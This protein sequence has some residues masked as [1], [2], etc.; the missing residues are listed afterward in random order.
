MIVSTFLNLRF[1]HSKSSIQNLLFLLCSVHINWTGFYKIPSY[2]IIKRCLMIIAITSRYQAP[3]FLRYLN[4]VSPNDNGCTNCYLVNPLKLPRQCDTI[5]ISINYMSNQIVAGFTR[6]QQ[7]NP[8]ST[9][10]KN[11]I[12]NLTNSNPFFSYI[13]IRT[14]VYT[15]TNRTYLLTT[16]NPHL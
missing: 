15:A 1:L 3:E 7:I 13:L 8:S 2:H 5:N 14:A 6:H 12:F 16:E 11:I 4:T 10:S 9:S